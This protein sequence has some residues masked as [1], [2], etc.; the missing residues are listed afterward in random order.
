MSVDHVS[1]QASRTSTFED[2]VADEVRQALADSGY[3]EL[4]RLEVLVD[5][6]EVCLRGHVSTRYLRQKAEFLTLSIPDVGI[7]RSEIEVGS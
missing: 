4:Q 2:D 1:P 3:A 6:H 5:G 7:L